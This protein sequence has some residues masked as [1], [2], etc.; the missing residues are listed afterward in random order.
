MNI[1]R[2]MGVLCAWLLAAACS[3]RFADVIAVQNLPDASPEA[4]PEASPGPAPD[5]CLEL[6]AAQ[7]AADTSEGCSLQPNRIGCVS[8]D[9]SCGLGSC[10][11]GDPFVRRSGQVLFLHGAPFVFTGTV[12]WGLAWADDGCQVDAYSSQ[13]EALAKTFDELAVMHMSVLR[14]WAFQSFAGASGTDFSRFD[15]LVARARSAGVR[16]IPVLENMHSDCT[17]GGSRDD[18]WFATG[19]QRPYG[20]YALSYRDY[21]GRVVRHFR[22]EPTIMAWELMHEAVGTQFTSLDAFAADMSSVVRTA[23]PNHL[24]ALGL[25]VSASP[26]L[27]ATS[28]NGEVSNYFK[29]QDR[30]EIDLIDVHDFNAPDEAIPALTAQCRVIARA[31]GKPIFVGAAA[32]KLNDA[33]LASFAQRANQVERK[34]QAA[35]ADDFRGFLVYD[36]VPGWS[37][38]NFDFDSR[39]EDPLAGPSGVLARAAATL[40][41]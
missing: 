15:R 28:V 6:E 27:I 1:Q 12:S 32:V 17:T 11:G 13:D 21:V 4:S 22:D 5:H 16:L 8:T 3:T 7:C 19:Y 25:D 23:D 37:N 9:P 31:L 20:S 10:A 39:S 2:A 35:I 34:L 33:S 18:A 26:T 14:F 29:L 40:G 41:H 38:P 24:I 30:P 36:Y